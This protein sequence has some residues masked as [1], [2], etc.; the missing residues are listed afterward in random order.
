MTLVALPEGKKILERAAAGVLRCLKPG[1]GKRAYLDQDALRQSYATKG[2]VVCTAG[3]GTIVPLAEFVTPAIRR[4]GDVVPM[5]LCRCGCGEPLEA[6][7]SHTARYRVEC[8][9]RLEREREQQDYR[10]RRVR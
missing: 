2:E 5:P 8:R 10:R 3:H 1:C 9:L 7:R 6:G 4:H